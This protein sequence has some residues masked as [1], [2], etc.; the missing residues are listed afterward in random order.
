MVSVDRDYPCAKIHAK[1]AN[2]EDKGKCL[3]LDGGVTF[4]MVIQLPAEEANRVFQPINYLEQSGANGRVR[5]VYG[6]TERK[7]VVWRSKHR[8]CSQ[9]GL[10]VKEAASASLVHTKRPPFLS[11]SERTDVMCA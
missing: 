5:C 1:I 11:K 9:T 7:R 10:Q 4:F 3:F 2:S 6:Q 8:L